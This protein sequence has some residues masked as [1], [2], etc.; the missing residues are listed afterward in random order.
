MM[1]TSKMY[2]KLD[3]GRCVVFDFDRNSVEVR[4]NDI[5]IFVHVYKQ[6]LN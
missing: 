2:G 3:D 4:R 5:I 6:D 1:R